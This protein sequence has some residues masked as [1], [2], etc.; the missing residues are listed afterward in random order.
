MESL[1]QYVWGQVTALSQ[2]K[3]PLPSPYQPPEQFK[4]KNPDE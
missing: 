4:K 1:L 3:A 2:R